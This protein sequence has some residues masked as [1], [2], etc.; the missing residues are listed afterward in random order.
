V[1]RSGWEF[2][3]P[4]LDYCHAYVFSRRQ[5]VPPWLP[6]DR[7]WIIPPSID[8]L[9]PKN[10]D[11]D[12]AT[13]RAVLGAAG[14]L[15]GPTAG[16]AVFVRRDGTRDIVTRRA[17]VVADSL[18]GPGEP[19]ILQVSRWDR[20]KDMTGVLTAFA[21]HV[22]PYVA[23][24]LALVGPS[25]AGVADDPEGAAVYAECLRLWTSLPDTARARAMLISLPL[26]DVDENAVM[27]NALQRHAT[28]VAQKSLAEGFGLTVAEAMWKARPVIGSAVGG[29]PDQIT[30]G[31]GVLLPVPTDLESFGASVCNLLTDPSRRVSLGTAA[32]E[33]VRS[34]FLGD[35][36]LRR[37]AELLVRLMR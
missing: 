11:L 9:A 36:H 1:T 4:Y 19:M 34:V 24:R 29:I 30:A 20:L 22:A 25:T 33:R 10:Q 6:A 26:D 17:I 18:P 5:F 35:L 21:R 32:R 28:I 8:P 14:I 12:P 31:T 2:L 27:V 15:D 16:P 37:Y 7:A 3:Q 13:V 23:G